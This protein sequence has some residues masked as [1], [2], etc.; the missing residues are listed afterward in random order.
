MSFPSIY[1]DGYYRVLSHTLSPE[2]DGLPH[3]SSSG[4]GFSGSLRDIDMSWQGHRILN[5]K[6]TSSCVAH[7]TVAGMEILYKQRQDMTKDFNPFFHYALINGGEDEGAY[8][9]DSLKIMQ[10]YGICELSAFPSDK[11]YYKSSLTKSAYDNALR[12]KLDKAYRCTT[13]EEVCSALNL[14]FVVNIGIMVGSN[15][16]RVDSE[17]MAPLP[18][19]GGGG[20]SM[21]ACGLK[22]HNKWG[23]TVKLQNS[24]GANF[25]QN[26]YCYVRKEHFTY[27]S[28]LDCFAFQGVID[29]PKDPVPQDDVPIVKV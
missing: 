16:T 11:V 12:Y 1:F 9:S 14:G 29:D 6:N 8:I 21:L 27:Y 13:F 24:W 7:A 17:G 4:L 15:F 19:G 10:Q 20:H 5:Q 23:W 25:G 28:R 26:G 18:N 3:F 22:Y 2:D